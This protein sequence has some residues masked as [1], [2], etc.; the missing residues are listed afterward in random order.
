M[1]FS[2]NFLGIFWFSAISPLEQGEEVLEGWVTI[3]HEVRAF[4]PCGRQADLW[5]LGQS[6]ALKLIMV[7]HH[8]APA[9]LEPYTRVF[10][11]LAGRITE[12]PTDGF[13]ADYDAA[14]LATQFVR[15]WPK[16]KC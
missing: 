6:P 7:A 5:L 15:V 1:I 4:R 16:G 13:G 9:R 3:G 12:R 14:F 2:R 8:D 11:V 10:M